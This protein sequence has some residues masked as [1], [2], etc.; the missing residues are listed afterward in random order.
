MWRANSLEK[1]LKLGKT[2]GKRRKGQQRMRWLDGI[3]DSMD[4]SVSKLRV[5]EGQGS[6][7][8]CSSWDHKN[9]TRLSDWTTT[10]TQ[11]LWPQVQSH[12][13]LVFLVDMKGDLTH[14]TQL[15][16]WKPIPIFLK[17][18]WFICTQ[19]Y[20]RH[21]PCQTPPGCFHSQNNFAPYL[22][23]PSYVELLVFSVQSSLPLMHCPYSL[24]P[25]S[26]FHSPESGLAKVRDIP[27]WESLLKEGGAE[28][29]RS[30]FS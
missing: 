14:N 18:F 11:N 6:L 4:M 8:C 2:E 1:T 5:S 21:L 19:C 15:Y 16:Y 22:L 29:A 13:V 20:L 26:I 9:R 12:P 10:K 7:E 23:P 24:V 30:T 27:C 28:G 17:L 3:T 25:L